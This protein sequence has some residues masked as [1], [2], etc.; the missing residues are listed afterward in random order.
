[1]SIRLSQ[2]VVNELD[3]ITDYFVPL[4]AIASKIDTETFEFELN[5]RHLIQESAE[6]KF[7]GCLKRALEDGPSQGFEQ[8]VAFLR[9]NPPAAD[10][11]GVW[12]ATEK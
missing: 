4:S 5:L 2:G 7:Q 3:T 12:H 1:L 9:A 11:Q 6:E 10:W 8:R